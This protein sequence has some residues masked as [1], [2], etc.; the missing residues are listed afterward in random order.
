[1][2]RKFRYITWNLWYTD[3]LFPRS[4]ASF[5]VFLWNLQ[6]FF[7]WNLQIFLSLNIQLAVRNTWQALWEGLVFCTLRYTVLRKLRNLMWMLPN[8]SNHCNCMRSSPSSGSIKRLLVLS[9]NSLLFPRYNLTAIYDILSCKVLQQKAVWSL[10]K[11]IWNLM[12]FLSSY[13]QCKMYNF[14]NLTNSW[15]FS[16]QV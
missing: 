1:M 11:F 9:M 4:I 15:N 10:L 3:G 8:A 13:T 16:S 12:S 7:L 2:I 14:L 6:I 5:P